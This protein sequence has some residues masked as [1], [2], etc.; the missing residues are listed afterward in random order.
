MTP[1]VE[2]APIKVSRLSDDEA[3]VTLPRWFVMAIIGAVAA[4]FGAFLKLDTHIGSVESRMGVIEYRLG[5]MPGRAQRPLVQFAPPAAADTLQ[6]V[7][8]KR[9]RLL[10]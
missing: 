6:S 8:A 5:I 4:G 9:A 2:V 10:H 3:S 7:E 1:T